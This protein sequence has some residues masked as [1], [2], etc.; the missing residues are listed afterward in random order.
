MPHSTP[1]L[2]QLGKRICAY[3]KGHPSHIRNKKEDQY[4]GPLERPR[5][6]FT[7]PHLQRYLVF[8]NTDNL[9]FD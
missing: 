4:T 8:V 2:E 3:V 5:R 1:P 7:L 9:D 6:Y